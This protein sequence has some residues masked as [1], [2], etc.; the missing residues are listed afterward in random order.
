M[1]YSA[2]YKYK[3]PLSNASVQC[4]VDSELEVKT[5]VKEQVTE[6]SIIELSGKGL[7]KKGI[8]IFGIMINYNDAQLLKSN[9]SPL[10]GYQEC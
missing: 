5:V 10:L 7:L 2:G 4:N 1:R 3:F 6:N 8:Y 9:Y